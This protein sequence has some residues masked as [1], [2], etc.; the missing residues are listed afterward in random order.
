[1]GCPG[2]PGKIHIA[3]EEVVHV[4]LGLHA[5]IRLLP[6]QLLHIVKAVRFAK[7]AIVKKVI[8]HP[9]VRHG[10]LRADRL[11]RRMRV[12]AC[13]HCQKARVGDP[14]HSNPSVVTRHVLQQ[15]IDRVA[16]VSRLVHVGLSRMRNNGTVHHEL[17]FRSIA[18]ANVLVYK[19]IPARRQ[20][21]LA[22]RHRSRRVT[23]HPVRRTLHQER[24][25]VTCQRT[26]GT[27][28]HGMQ[29]HAIP[30][31]NRGFRPDILDVLCTHRNNPHSR[32][33]ARQHPSHDQRL[34]PVCL[35]FALTTALSAKA[36]QTLERNKAES[37][38][39]SRCPKVRH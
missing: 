38:I 37:G 20:L 13:H 34:T 32:Q 2:C 29:L 17:P 31:R 1:M 27:H 3:K 11:H 4:L 14:Q 18:P 8:T 15:P 21:R 39:L 19:D 10:R 24:Q 22:T 5:Y 23:I 26:L 35:V 9:D 12:H 6:F 30:H 33:S 16:R 25:R 36:T 7:R 28:N